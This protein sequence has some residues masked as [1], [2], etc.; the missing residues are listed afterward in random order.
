MRTMLMR[1]DTLLALYI[2]FGAYFTI[3]L[4]CGVLVGLW[5]EN[6]ELEDSNINEGTGNPDRDD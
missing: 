5:T 6:P 4:V 1:G 2:I 3:C